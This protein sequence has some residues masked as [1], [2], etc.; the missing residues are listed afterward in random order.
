M[1]GSKFTKQTYLQSVINAATATTESSRRTTQDEGTACMTPITIPG[2]EITAHGSLG[3]TSIITAFLCLKAK[4]TG[5][6]V[7]ERS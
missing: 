5:K 2:R 4:M 6:Y 3:D 7:C 1:N